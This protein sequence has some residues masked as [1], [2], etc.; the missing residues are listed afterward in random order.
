MRA[1]CVSGIVDVVVII[2]IIIIIIIV[3]IVVIVQHRQVNTHASAIG[4][5]GISIAYY[6][7]AFHSTIDHG[8]A[9]SVRIEFEDTVSSLGALFSHDTWWCGKLLPVC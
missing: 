5:I 7:A 2:I 3:F 6:D 9:R 4:C 8:S 1:L